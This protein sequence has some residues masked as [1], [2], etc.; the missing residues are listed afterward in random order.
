MRV[1]KSWEEV[2]FTPIPQLLISVRVK[3]FEGKKR[4]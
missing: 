2:G 4:D 1:E 3:R